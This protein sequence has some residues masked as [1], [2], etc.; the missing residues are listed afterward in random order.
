MRVLV[1]AYHFPPIGGAGSQRWL[2]LVRYIPQADPALEL[3]VLTGPGASVDRWSPVDESLSDELPGPRLVHRV[4]GPEPPDESRWRARLERWLFVPTAWTRWWVDAVLAEGLRRAGECDVIVASM[5]P[6]ASAPAAARL[7]KKLRR[8]WVADL[9][10]PWALDEMLIYPSG[11][12]RRLDVRRMRRLL[13]SAAAVVTTTPEAVRRIRAAFPELVGR[14]IVSIP[15]GFDPA[16]FAGPP[17]VRDDDAFR[18]VHTGY[19]HTG[20]GLE[21]RRRR[22]ALRRLRGG[23]VSG[24]D[25]LTRSHV[26]LV[27]AIGRVA[28]RDPVGGSRIEL[29]LAG[30]LSEADREVASRVPGLREHGYLPHAGAVDLMRSADLLFLPMQS[31]PPGTRAG[32]VPGKTYEYL[33]AGRP[34]LAAVPQGDTRDILSEAGNAYICDPDDVSAIESAVESALRGARPGAPAPAVLDRFDRRR[35]AADY[36]QLLTTIAGAPGGI[37]G[38]ASAAPPGSRDD[39]AAV[40]RAC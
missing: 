16:D 31:V 2:K 35:T 39:Q 8:P 6:F 20:L 24:T 18:I 7:A 19:L 36:A 26:Y 23:A 22:T 27:E 33:A 11:V 38:S 37:T 29:H 4:A 32:I 5:P 34:I 30:L 14:P 21:Q 25:I 17:K 15:N 1:V 13:R 10:D 40:E 12:H 3:S 9:R 28:A